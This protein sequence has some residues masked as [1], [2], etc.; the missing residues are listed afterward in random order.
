MI[1]RREFN[2]REQD[3]ES[4]KFIFSDNT[5]VGYTFDVTGEERFRYTL[6]GDVF[7]IGGGWQ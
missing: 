6:D 1:V 3:F 4:G 2:Q 5:S 7:E